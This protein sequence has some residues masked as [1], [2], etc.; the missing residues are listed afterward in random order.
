M[1]HHTFRSHDQYLPKI[2]LYASLGAL[3]AFQRGK[4]TS[5]TSLIF[6]PT[7]R[8]LKDYVLRAGFLDGIPGLCIAWLAAYSMY[9]KQAKLWEME[10][11][12]VEVIETTDKHR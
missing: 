3:E 2:Q 11:S 8:F 9:L 4:R 1:E 6:S 7:F 12:K 5:I 10:N